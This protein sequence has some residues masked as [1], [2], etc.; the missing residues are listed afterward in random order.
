[1]WFPC[2]IALCGPPRGRHGYPPFAAPSGALGL[3]F[4]SHCLHVFGEFRQNYL[5]FAFGTTVS[6]F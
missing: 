4:V 5:S 3:L 2:L 1:M 6:A